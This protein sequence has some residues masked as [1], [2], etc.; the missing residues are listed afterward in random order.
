MSRRRAGQRASTMS[1]RRAG[2]RARTMSRRRAGQRASTMS[3]RRAGQRAKTVSRQRAGQR[4]RTM[5]RQQRAGQRV[6]T[7]SRQQRAGGERHCWRAGQATGDASRLVVCNRSG[8]R[9]ACL[10]GRKLDAP[11]QRVWPCVCVEGRAERRGASVVG[12]VVVIFGA[13]VVGAVVVG[14]RSASSEVYTRVVVVGAVVV[15]G[16]TSERVSWGRLRLSR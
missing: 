14:E 1:R 2:Q 5:S 3:R 8:R 10:G 16:R 7:M 13:S 15:V 12:A 6:K 9:V 11:F 4:V